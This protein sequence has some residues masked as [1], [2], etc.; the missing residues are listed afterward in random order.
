MEPMALGSPASPS[1]GTGVYS[2][3]PQSGA[4]YLPGFLMG[5]VTS[6]GGGRPFQTSPM[7]M[8]KGSSTTGYLSVSPPS[9]SVPTPKANRLIGKTDKPGGPPVQRLFS[10][11]GPSTPSTP[12]DYAHLPSTPHA[13][14][15]VSSQVDQS[16]LFEDSDAGT[17]V[18][19]FGFPPSAASYVLTQT[20]MWGH[21]MEHRIPSQ[22]NWM[23]LKFASRLQAR[24]ALARNGRLLT[25]TLMI[26]VVPCTDGAIMEES[27]KENLQAISTP[28]MRVTSTPQPAVW[29][30]SS[31]FA[32]G[33]SATPSALDRSNLRPLTQTYKGA[34]TDYEVNQQRATP[35][36]N[37][38]LVAK[39]MDFVFGW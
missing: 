24:K 17:W 34:Q 25:D 35:Q 36:Q 16:D 38:S 20:G 11:T 33:T 37:S 3:Q 12:S 15:S 27:R 6:Q 2:N 1:S 39:A 29:D 21:I 18:T 8:M 9:S 31:S 19:V 7:K 22:G 32:L 23:H 30:R 4:Q 26:G 10:A 13:N 28:S 14:Y 5:D